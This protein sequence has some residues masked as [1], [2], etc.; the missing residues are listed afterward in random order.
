MTDD[1]AQPDPDLPRI[2]CETGSL[3]AGPGATGAIWR[4]QPSLRDLDANVIQLP[5]QARI[6]GHIGPDLDV[7]VTVL[8]G[9]GTLTTELTTV[10]MR[11]GAIIWLPRRSYR[12][13]TAGPH[14]LR[15]LT[16]HLRRQVPLLSPSVVRSDP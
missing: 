5:A 12:Q 6:D 2:V 4:L 13:F 16:V 7:V 1:R 10:D 9:S 8:A 15:Y 14:G 3:D 11:V